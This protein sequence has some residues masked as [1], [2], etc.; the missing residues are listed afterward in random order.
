MPEQEQEQQELK[1]WQQQELPC[2]VFL[3]KWGR[4]AW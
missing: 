2:L 1:E 4:T 3:Q